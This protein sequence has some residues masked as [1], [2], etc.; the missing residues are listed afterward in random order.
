[1]QPIT[2]DIPGI[3]LSH[4]FRQLPCAN[5]AEWVEVLLRVKTLGDPRNIVLDGGPAGPD[6]FHG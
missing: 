4:G 5:T 2:V 3:C 6:L 1:M